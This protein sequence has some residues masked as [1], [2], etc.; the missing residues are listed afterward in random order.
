RT[1]IRPRRSDVHVVG[2]GSSRAGGSRTAKVVLAP[3]DRLALLARSCAGAGEVIRIRQ[4]IDLY[5][6][7][8]RGWAHSRPAHVLLLGNYARLSYVGSDHLRAAW[9]G[10]ELE[11]HRCGHLEPMMAVASEIAKADIVVGYGR[12]ILEAMA[13]AR[14]AYVH[15]HS[16]SDGWVTADT[17]SR[18]EAD[19]FAGT[20]IR[21]SPSADE[22]RKDFERYTPALGGVGHD[23][24]HAHHDARLVTAALMRT[25]AG[26]DP[27]S[28]SYDREALSSIK[29]L[30]LLLYR[31]NGMVRA[32]REEMRVNRLRYESEVAGLKERIGK[33][34]LIQAQQK[35]LLLKQ[36]QKRGAG[37]R[38]KT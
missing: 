27:P 28:H 22:L 12:S 20:A 8:P 23:L 38:K 15:E 35:A 37:S 32:L 6:F 3:N 17:Y 21:L 19:G 1:F 31:S 10:H 11:W 13:C 26:F 18:L 4:P 34:E 33:A 36:A 29:N 25:I 14:P 2:A 5:R 24:I 9:S 30:S 16:G 7:L